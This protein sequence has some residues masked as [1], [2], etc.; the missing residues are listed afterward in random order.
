[1][2]RSVGP[3]LAFLSLGSLGAEPTSFT[4]RPT[5]VTLYRNRASVLFSSRIQLEK[6]KHTLEHRE[7]VPA[8]I[9]ESLRATTDSGQIVIQGISSFLDA[10]EPA[11]QPEIQELQSRIQQKDREILKLEYEIQRIQTD[12]EGINKY[13]ELLNTA[14]SRQAAGAAEAR[15][16]SRTVLIERKLKQTALLGETRE[17]LR[18]K[19]EEVIRLRRDLAEKKDRLSH[20]R[21]TV[22]ITLYANEPTTFHLGYH[23]IVPDAGWNVSYSLRLSGRPEL[24]Y[25]A[26]AYQKTGLDWNGVKLFFS[27]AEPQLAS[28]RPP[29]RP[30]SASL[31]RAQDN[32]NIVVEQE[33]SEEVVDSDVAEPESAEEARLVFQAGQA[34]LKSGN[35]K[36]LFLLATF[37]PELTDTFLRVAGRTATGT[38][39]R[40]KH[41]GDTPLLAGPVDLIKS[42]GWS[43][44]SALKRTPPG[45][46]FELSTA[47]A[48]NIKQDRSVS[49]RRETSL[50]GK[51]IFHTIVRNSLQNRSREKQRLEIQERLPVS[52]LSEVSVELLDGGEWQEKS[53]TS[54]IRLRQVMLEPGQKWNYEFHYTVTVPQTFQ[55]TLYGD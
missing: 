24:K 36:H 23:A 48:A 38:V 15:E 54:G 33:A 10:A 6:G 40:L 3:F 26:E 34:S 31:V 29:L 50:G 46:T 20:R 42:S 7:A 2:V 25:Y 11:R 30:L 55:G 39:Y 47:G 44:R 17:T 4:A 14:L 9:P 37:Q 18:K 12:I 28:E 13:Y 45:V 5:E 27:T 49:H 41:N 22:Q 8:L 53:P 35:E 16:Q 43:G 19:N 52:E 1:M 21:R 32:R 51:Q